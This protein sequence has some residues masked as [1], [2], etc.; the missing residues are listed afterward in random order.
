MSTT[1]TRVLLFIN[2]FNDGFAMSQSTI[3]I[4]HHV[5]SWGTPSDQRLVLGR[6]SGKSDLL[7][8]NPSRRPPCERDCFAYFT[9]AARDRV[10][11]IPTRGRERRND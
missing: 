9:L 2:D 6:R 11:A 8:S 1:F 5:S 4:N 3:P 7:K 10:G